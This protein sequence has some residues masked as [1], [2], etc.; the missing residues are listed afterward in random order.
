MSGAGHRDPRSSTAKRTS[1]EGSSPLTEDEIRRIRNKA[2]SPPKPLLIFA[3]VIVVMTISMAVAWRYWLN[4]GDTNGGV[5]VVQTQAFR[6]V[7][8]GSDRLDVRLMP[9]DRSLTE[10]S[11]N[12][13]SFLQ[14]I[15]RSLERQ[16]LVDQ[17]SA[18]DAPFRITYWS[19]GRLTLEDPTTDTT[20]ALQAYG[21][22]NTAHVFQLLEMATAPPE[23]STESPRL[24]VGSDVEP[25]AGSGGASAQ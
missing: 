16:R 19:D 20:I 23:A 5:T 25:D 7:P 15:V 10:V 9:E 17:V 1:P 13:S 11:G 14:G 24:D 8:H 22:D 2:M 12:L 3:A 6:F 4:P 18:M 21:L